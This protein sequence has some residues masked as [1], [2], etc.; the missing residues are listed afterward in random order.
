MVNKIE[1]QS[2]RFSERNSP[3]EHA[4]LYENVVQVA[5]EA[6]AMAYP[7]NL[8]PDIKFTKLDIIQ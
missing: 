3:G 2:E 1:A 5:D 6:S 4:N 8:V 7:T